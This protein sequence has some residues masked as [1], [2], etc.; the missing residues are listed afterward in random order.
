MVGSQAGAGI[1]V[2]GTVDSTGVAISLLRFFFALVRRFRFRFRCRS[3]S[4]L[5]LTCSDLKAGSHP[6]STYPSRSAAWG[7][8]RVRGVCEGDVGRRRRWEG[9]SHAMTDE[10]ISSALVAMRAIVRIGEM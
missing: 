5:T 9:P 2:V 3:S 4:G 6:R 8:G 7:N 1:A 10:S